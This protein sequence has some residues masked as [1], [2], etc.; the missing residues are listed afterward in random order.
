MGRYYSGDIEGKFWFAVQSSD[1]ADRFGV[2]GTEPNYLEYYFQEDDLPNIEQG[3]KEIEGTLGE[4][5]QKMED[6]FKTV[7]YYNDEEL[8]EAIG[9]EM[10]DVRFYLREYADYTLGVEIRDYVIEHGECEF[11]AELG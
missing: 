9:V 2:V 3:L 11:T 5:L 4:Y 8:A 10:E 6:F 7:S 1:A